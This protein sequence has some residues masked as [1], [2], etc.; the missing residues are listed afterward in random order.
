MSQQLE[1]RELV[2]A[3]LELET[4]GSFNFQN[5]AQE[6]IQTMKAKSLRSLLEESY[7]KFTF[8]F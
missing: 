1:G 7:A 3:A 6:K 8:W 5:E 2:R 4:P